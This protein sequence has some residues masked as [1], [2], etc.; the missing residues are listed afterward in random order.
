[1]QC[2]VKGVC[3]MKKQQ[4]ATLAEHLR[5]IIYTYYYAVVMFISLAATVLLYVFDLFGALLDNT[6]ELSVTGVGIASFLFAVQ[7]IILAIPADNPFIQAVRQ[8]GKYFVFIHK[9]CR[10]AEIV[11]MLLLLPMLYLKEQRPTFWFISPPVEPTV[12]SCLCVCMYIYALIL[13]IWAMW[14]LCNIFISS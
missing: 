8:D 6:V 5:L 7:G 12:F 9:F 10:N 11:F 13:T 3:C 1:M 14:L 4:Q 2:D